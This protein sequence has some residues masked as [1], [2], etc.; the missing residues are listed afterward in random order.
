MTK[1]ENY[2]STFS[3][4]LNLMCAILL[5]I[6]YYSIYLRPLHMELH[7]LGFV[8]FVCPI[9]TR[10]RILSSVDTFSFLLKRCTLFQHGIC[11]IL[12]KQTNRFLTAT[13][14]VRI[15]DGIAPVI[16]NSVRL[17]V[18]GQLWSTGNL[19]NMSV[20]H[21]QYRIF[22]LELNLF[23]LGKA[24]VLLHPF[25]EQAHRAFWLQ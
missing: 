19:N 13:A 22:F 23:S 7:L 25:L 8:P 18:C 9:L 2:W 17:L 21:Q 5:E 15:K 24:R 1:F 3:F 12:P 16:R 10:E 20:W 14:K 6:L 11:S 4:V